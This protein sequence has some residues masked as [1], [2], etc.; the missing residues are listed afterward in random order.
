MK[1]RKAHNDYSDVAI[2]TKA[3]GQAPARLPHAMEGFRDRFE[4]DGFAF[5]AGK[6]LLA[7]VSPPTASWLALAAAVARCA[8]VDENSGGRESLRH[9]HYSTGSFS[10]RAAHGNRFH[11]FPP[12][13]DSRGKVFTTYLQPA[14]ANRDY[15]HERRFDP[16]PDELLCHRGL[17]EIVELC[18]RATPGSIFPGVGA[19]L[20]KVG[21]HLIS[22]QPEK[23]RAAI[24]S[25]NR[26]HFDGEYVTFIV[27]LER[28]GVV[29]GDSLVVERA[30]ADWHPDDVPEESRLFRATLAEPLDMLGTDDRRICHY[31]YPV[32]A[33]KNDCGR[34]SVLLVDFT[35]LVGEMSNDR[36]DGE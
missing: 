14:G 29:G 12:Y 32:F 24:S 35:P 33:R 16:L 21:I 17:Q 11:L 30:Y 9:R 26:A 8:P 20:L 2:L 27:M 3:G 31:V 23:G 13:V 19:D 25:P 5:Q 7:A 36:L 18:Y 34:R 6:D 10:R 4:R 22:L 1:P 28:A 15:G